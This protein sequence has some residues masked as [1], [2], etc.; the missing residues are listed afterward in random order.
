M[1]RVLTCGLC[2]RKYLAP[3]GRVYDNGNRVELC[4]PADSVGPMT[5]YHRWTVYGERPV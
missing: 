2:G 4:H 1:N 5:C 3:E